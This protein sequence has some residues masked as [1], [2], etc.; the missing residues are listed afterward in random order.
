MSLTRP[1]RI[2]INGY[3]RIGRCVL[4]A[5][6]E[7]PRRADFQVV[8]IN[9]PADIATMA[10]L[11]Q[12]DSTHGVFP[13]KVDHDNDHLIVAGAPIRVLHETRP[14]AVDWHA[15][16]LDML[17]ECSGAY[18]D[19]A[20][21]QAFL[22]AGCPR[23]LVSNPAHSAHDVDF[24]VVLG[25]NDEQLQGSERI[26]SNASCTTN[27]I[28]PVLAQL[29]EAFGIRHAFLS[30]LHS[31]MNDQPMIDGYHSHDLRRT[32]SAL[33]SMIP[34][35]TGLAQGVERLLPQLKGKV[36]AKSI[37]VPILNVS[38][39]DLMV[40]LQRDTSQDEIN[41]LFRQAVQRWP[42]IL[43]YSERPHASI[44]FNHNP[45]SGVVDGTQTRTNGDG[46]VNMLV[47]FDNEWGFSN[48][49]LDIACVWASRF[50]REA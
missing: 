43:D 18:G 8:A 16:D 6:H 19:R 24:T 33:Q 25:I 50:Q 32:R 2:A 4:R 37:R 1:I 11:T 9:E 41:T 3:G 45:H 40:N 22:D 12:F 29:D 14:D 36:Q 30:T 5:I 26:V 49:L 47:W 46:L 13:G 21:L 38:A 27:A 35:S 31:V 20:Q 7:S 44:D 48:R 15:L 42:G 10:Y 39:I 34:V 17:I 23:I 28:I